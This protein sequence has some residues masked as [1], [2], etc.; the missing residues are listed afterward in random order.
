VTAY[1]GRD[2]LTF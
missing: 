1:T 2:D